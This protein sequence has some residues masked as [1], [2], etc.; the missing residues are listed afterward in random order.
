MT[1]T[2]SQI[3]AELKATQAAFDAYHAEICAFNDSRPLAEGITFCETSFAVAMWARISHLTCQLPMT[4]GEKRVADILAAGGTF[5][6]RGFYTGAARVF[7][8]NDR[9]HKGYALRE[10]TVLSLHHRGVL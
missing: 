7:P 10:S 2:Q 9:Q 4:K 1:K 6:K 8:A 5:M 3:R